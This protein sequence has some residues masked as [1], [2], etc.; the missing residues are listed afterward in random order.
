MV[1]TNIAAAPLPQT[2]EGDLVKT[3]S[4]DGS[5][6][7]C[8]SFC[9]R[10]KRNQAGT[11]QP[12]EIDPKMIRI[13]SDP[14]WLE[15]GEVQK[16]E[17]FWRLAVKIKP[18]IEIRPPQQYSWDSKGNI[19]EGKQVRYQ[20]GEETKPQSPKENEL[21]KVQ[22]TVTVQ[23]QSEA[24]LTAATAMAG[25]IPG[26]A[27]AVAAGL[28]L[29]K[30]VT[31]VV[32]PPK[33]TWLASVQEPFRLS[34][35]GNVLVQ[36]EKPETLENDP[37]AIKVWTY[38]LPPGWL[39]QVTVVAALS[40]VSQ[41]LQIELEKIEPTPEVED[42]LGA[43]LRVKTN[44]LVLCPRD[45][46]PAKANFPNAFIE[47]IM[48]TQSRYL[49]VQVQK[50]AYAAAEALNVA[51]YFRT[52]PAKA[53]D[54]QPAMNFFAQDL[55]KVAVIP[56]DKLTSP[57][58]LCLLGV[59]LRHQDNWPP[60]AVNWFTEDEFEDLEME[61]SGGGGGLDDKFQEPANPTTVYQAPGLDSWEAAGK[62]A[63]RIIVCLVGSGPP[64]P[65]EP[66]PDHKDLYFTA[67]VETEI[68][69]VERTRKLRLKIRIGPK[70]F[71]TPDGLAK[72]NLYQP[73]EVEKSLI[74]DFTVDLEFM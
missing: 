74:R 67:P 20:V 66:V 49:G 40:Q 45:D 27:A 37:Q 15:M 9:L 16:E 64:G 8:E 35:P 7:V 24:L 25:I 18:G 69:L 4:W 62:P 54:W 61:T 47:L 14:D 41:K 46:I 22:L 32:Q 36:E 68:D 2:M 71:M 58:N 12:V 21:L 3:I 17:D 31:Y 6:W 30:V 73:A 60:P 50:G 70:E 13:K 19:K 44:R 33:V 28:G 38:S 57:P 59:Q 55:S 26:G 48:I 65:S 10:V 51:I 56:K 11:L 39:E 29:S 43:Y 72:L 53:H 42:E 5:Q 63:L 23:L 34:G 1:H 52:M